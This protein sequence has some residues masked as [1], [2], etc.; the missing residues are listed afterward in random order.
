MS[1]F[2]VF[3]K[4]KKRFIRTWARRRIDAGFA[5]LPEREVRLG[6]P[7]LEISELGFVLK[8][9]QFALNLRTYVA[10]KSECESIL[11]IQCTYGTGVTAYSGISSE[12]SSIFM[13]E[14]KNSVGYLLRFQG[15]ESLSVLDR[16]SVLLT[17]E[18]I[19]TGFVLNK[20]VY[21]YYVKPQLPFLT[22]DAIKNLFH[23]IRNGQVSSRPRVEVRSNCMSIGSRSSARF[24]SFNPIINNPGTG[25][26]KHLEIEC[27]L[28]EDAA[29]QF[30]FTLRN[31]RFLDFE[32]LLAYELLTSISKVTAVNNGFLIGHVRDELNSKFNLGTVQ[33]IAATAVETESRAI[34]AAYNGLRVAYSKIQEPVNS[35]STQDL[36]LKFLEGVVSL[37]PEALVPSKAD[38]IERGFSLFKGARDLLLDRPASPLVNVH[39]ETRTPTPTDFGSQPNAVKRAK[40]RLTKA[41]KAVVAVYRVLSLEQG[42]V[43]LQLA[44]L[45][46]SA[47]LQGSD[48]NLT[49]KRFA[50]NLWKMQLS[51]VQAVIAHR[52]L[53]AL[54]ATTI[55]KYP[56]ELKNESTFSGFDFL[57]QDVSV[58]MK[59]WEGVELTVEKKKDDP[60]YKPSVQ[61]VTSLHCPFILPKASKAAGP[62]QTNTVSVANRI[63]F[64]DPNAPPP[65]DPPIEDYD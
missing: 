6:T 35:L 34:S 4:H 61:L 41:L 64:P 54:D 18:E 25:Y 1:I 8:E 3:R 47:F 53:V 49:L 21:S 23:N 33:I 44:Q 56:P 65:M 57:N 51:Q 40:A 58:L 12:D 2:S 39:V 50:D 59:Y 46:T 30:F 29:S 31:S 13:G 27:R 52:E 17:E 43:N 63:V 14:N 19:R 37:P 42:R 48:V 60:G 24:V 28:T 15:S 38:F 62:R 10:V 20:V 9:I 16:I 32:N 55:Y 7:N 11:P 36:V 22:L 45:E 26:L 5:P